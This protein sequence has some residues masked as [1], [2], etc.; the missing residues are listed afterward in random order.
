[1]VRDLADTLKN[2]ARPGWGV[3]HRPLAD[4]LLHVLSTLPDADSFRRPAQSYLGC[5]RILYS[6]GEQA[7]LFPSQVWPSPDDTD[8][9]AALLSA[10][11]AHRPL[12]TMPPAIGAPPASQIPVPSRAE[13]GPSPPISAPA[14]VPLHIPTPQPPFAHPSQPAASA[15]GPSTWAYGPS[16]HLSPQG[17]DP[18]AARFASMESELMGLRAALQHLSVTQQRSQFGHTDAQGR[19]AYTTPAAALSASVSSLRA[20]RDPQV[21]VGR[22]VRWTG[23]SPII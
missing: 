21:S 22:P 11:E 5:A 20:W 15:A 18:S 7:F 23:V 17:Q 9:V 8:F 1:M 2:G 4:G 19:T 13:S 12:L 14:P 6:F 10:L 3:S 16:P